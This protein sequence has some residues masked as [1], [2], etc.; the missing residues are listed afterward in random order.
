MTILKKKQRFFA[1]CAVLAALVF[2]LSGCEDV[3]QLAEGALPSFAV[4]RSASVQVGSV[5]NNW[6]QIQN[7]PPQ[8]ASTSGGNDAAW[9][10]NLFVT[11]SYSN[12][13]ALYSPDGEAWTQIPQSQTT[14]DAAYIKDVA[15]LEDGYFWAVGQKAN[16][17]KVAPAAVSK[18]WTRI[19][20]SAA[21][22]VDF[23]AIAYASDLGIHVIGGTNG[24]IIYSEDGG[25]TWTS[26]N[27]TFGTQTIQ[28]IAYGRVIGTPYGLFVATGTSGY[29]AWSQDGIKWVSSTNITAKLV[30]SNSLKA[31]AY[32]EDGNF[33]AVS[34]YGLIVTGDPSQ[35]GGAP[36]ETWVYREMWKSSDPASEGVKVWIQA[37]AYG[38]G[39]WVV[40]AQGGRIAYTN[41]PYNAEPYPIPDPPVPVWQ[42]FRDGHY[43]PPFS[44]SGDFVNGL[45]YDKNL[46]A[47]IT[48]GGDNSPKALISPNP[49]TK[50]KPPYKQ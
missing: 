42:R 26:T 5:P 31:V 21:T 24:T 27:S 2:A 30:N 34:R 45:A 44:S 3:T 35:T 1:G 32:G 9:G 7:Y 20:Q 37:V 22:A 19:S 49:Y 28:G 10:E 23:Y 25:D 18:Q 48:T 17:A 40:G 47:W 41:N 16:I 46:D 15:Y 13:S 29:S 6:V 11:S 43:T 14:F 50:L 12:G 38:G 39:Y 33:V 36:G 8:G 4:S